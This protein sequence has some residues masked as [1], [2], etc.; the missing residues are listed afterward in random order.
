M[1]G[2]IHRWYNCELL[3]V[4]YIDVIICTCHRTVL[5][6]SRVHLSMLSGGTMLLCVALSM[7]MCIFFSEF[8]VWCVWWLCTPWISVFI[9]RRLW[10][11]VF[12]WLLVIMFL[13]VMGRTW[14][15]CA[16]QIKTNKEMMGAPLSPHWPGGEEQGKRRRSREREVWW[17][18]GGRP[19]FLFDL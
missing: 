4:C 18:G 10:E 14:K 17:G 15:P 9:S 19:G 12:P 11:D 6:S 13:G 16:A 1:S 3:L 5:L 7:C 8:F 2:S